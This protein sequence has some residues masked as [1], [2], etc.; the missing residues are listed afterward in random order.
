MIE[1]EKQRILRE[2]LPYIDG[3]MP[4]SIIDKEEDAKFFTNTKQFN[5][6]NH[7]AHGFGYV[8]RNKRPTKL[9]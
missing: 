6:Q 5:Q 9:W 7:P 4:K 2:H 3:F 8:N 1:Q